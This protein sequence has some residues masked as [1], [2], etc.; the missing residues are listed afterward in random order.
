MS[1]R[2]MVALEL[3]ASPNITEDVEKVPLSV[4]CEIV[5]VS[6]PCPSSGRDMSKDDDTLFKMAVATGNVNDPV[7]IYVISPSVNKTECA[8]VSV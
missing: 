1:L 8:V 3:E 2:V 7:S 5:S 6:T 4:V